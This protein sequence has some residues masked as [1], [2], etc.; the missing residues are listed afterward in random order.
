MLKNEYERLDGLYDSASEQVRAMRSELGA[1]NEDF[2]RCMETE[3]D[4]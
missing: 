2:E 3:F 1:I 4:E